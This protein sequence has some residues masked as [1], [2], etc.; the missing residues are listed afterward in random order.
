[1]RDA[2]VNAGLVPLHVLQVKGHCVNEKSRHDAILHICKY[3]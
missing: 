3:I 2:S 1:V